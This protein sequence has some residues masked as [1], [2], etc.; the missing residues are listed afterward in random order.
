MR[1]TNIIMCAAAIAVPAGCSDPLTP[2]PSGNHMASDAVMAR[3]VEGSYELDFLNVAHQPVTSLP[4]GQAVI[5]QAKVTG[6]FGLPAEGGWA[7]FQY[8]SRKGYPTGD[9]TRIDEAPLEACETTGEGRWRTL[10]TVALNSAGIAELQF[11]CPQLTP[12][13]GFRFKYAG[14]GSG[15]RDHT[16]AAENFSWY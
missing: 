3:S 12:L 11:C 1:I 5:L 2:P 15:T 4:F 9:A 8:C 10:L 7:V 16:V 6:A 14:H 13:I